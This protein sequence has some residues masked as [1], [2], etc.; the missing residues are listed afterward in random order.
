MCALGEMSMSNLQL[1]LEEITM[2]EA[3]CLISIR[4][5]KLLLHVFLLGGK[6]PCEGGRQCVHMKTVIRFS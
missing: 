4:R 6:M 3:C 2:A 1:F 5:S